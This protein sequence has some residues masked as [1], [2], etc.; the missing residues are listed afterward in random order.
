MSK[1][2]GDNET[3]TAV[4]GNFGVNLNSTKGTNAI[5]L[6][7]AITDSV[8]FET[9]IQTRTLFMTIVRILTVSQMILKNKKKMHP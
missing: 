5:P 8:S 3:S 1:I 4:D 6:H 9:G 2:N 7:Y